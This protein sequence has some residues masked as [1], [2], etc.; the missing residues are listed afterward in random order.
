[1]F[2]IW[3]LPIYKE[4]ITFIEPSQRINSRYTT[5]AKSDISYAVVVAVVV[6]AT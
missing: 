6:S 4:K 2:S 5:T 1:M 3:Y